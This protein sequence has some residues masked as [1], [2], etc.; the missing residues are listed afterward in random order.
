[1]SGATI[2]ETQT[3]TM[4]MPVKR[5]LRSLR[6]MLLGALLAAS[7]CLLSAGSALAAGTPQPA[8]SMHVS[9]FPTNFPPDIETEGVTGPAYLITATN[10]GASPTTGQFAVTDELP[11]GI[12]VSPL[13]EPTGIYYRNGEHGELACSTVGQTVTCKSFKVLV[14]NE[15]TEEEE[16]VFIPLNPGEVVKVSIFV[17]VGVSTPS[18]LTNTTSIEGGGATSVTKLTPTTISSSIADFGFS[19][20]PAGLEGTMIN[21]D[22]SVATQASS[23]PDEAELV[24][25]NFTRYARP[26]YFS[27][28]ATD[29]GLRDVYTNLP[30]GLVVNPNAVPKCKESQLETEQGCPIDTQV[31]TVSL[32]LSLVGDYTVTPVPLFNM[33]APGGV[34]ASFGFEIIDGIY[35]HIEGSVRTGGDYGLSAET[36]DILAKVVVGG[37]SANFWGDPTADSHNNV[38]GKCLRLFQFSHD[39]CPPTERLN[40]ALITMPSQCTGPI[41]TTMG[42]D[43]WNHPNVRVERTFESQDPNGNPVGVDGCNKVDFEPAIKSRPTTNVAD[44]PTGLDFNLHLTQNMEPQALSPAN[45]KD[46]RVT[47]PPGM[48]LNPSAADGLEGCTS[49]Q[50]DLNG[51]N[52]ANCPDTSKIGTLEVNTPLLEKPL[53]GSIYVAKPFDNP[54]DSLLAIYLAV[55]D[56]QTGVVVKLAGKAEP[57]PKT[58]QLTTTFSENPELPF[59]DFKLSFFKGT[60]AALK[61]A[62]FCGSSFQT[63]SR[64]TP[65]SSPEGAD[66]T[67]SD[68]FATTVAPVSGPCPTSEA[69]LP[70]KPTFTAGTVAP[71]AGAYSPFVLKLTRP[72][73]S[74][75]LTAIDATLPKGL[76]GKLAGIPYCSE[77]QIAAAKSREA[78]NQ[79]ALER[80]SPS[81]PLASEVGTVSVGA[82]AGISPIYVQGHAYLS[83]PY[84]GAPLSMTI[85]TP[86]VAGPFDLGSVVV[87]TALYVDSETAQIHAVSDPLPTIMD[88]IQLDVRSIAVALDRPSFTL[89]PTSCDPKTITGLASAALGPAAALSSPFQVG[90]CSALPFK[91]DLRLKLKGGTKRSDHPALTAVATAKPGEANIAS[92][93]AALPHS[94]F[95][96]Q[97]HI[98][99]ICT[100]VQF[101]AGA[102]PGEKCPAAS[103]YGRATATT[104]LLAEP[105]SGPVFLRSSSHPLPDLVAALHGQVDVVVAGRVDSVH[106]GIR[107]S[108]EAVPDAPVTKFTLEMQGGKKGLIVNS[109]DIC[110]TPQRAT[111]LMEAQ[112]GK[113]HDFKPVIKNS[114]KK[115]HKGHKKSS[116]S[117]R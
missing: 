97:A 45:L 93:S 113:T 39:V 74:Q 9:T 78:V 58:G 77:A 100:R 115:K 70:N 71:A 51:P 42:I 87:R 17:D 56:P 84:K 55:D 63:T 11:A 88:G 8:F 62:P 85:I 91:P 16:E 95:L 92:V 5:A 59:E 30:H 106:G 34:V 83:G 99:T 54:F 6:P 2:K 64:M 53:P 66:A 21:A 75:R 79:G 105:L 104:P 102:V 41:G 112:N 90:G 15:E 67:P 37:V 12:T 48:V 23:H 36:N 81:C 117:H 50:I 116:K 32:S 22:G 107:N 31:G 26:E 110:K 73:G 24:A 89:N 14:F 61:T 29:G 72:D 108:F 52:P 19:A 40:T 111:V 60:R 98:K 20:G 7:L 38:R 4:N 43:S 1:V 76:T 13:I 114:C 3:M 27:S 47:L 18:T 68:S 28:F 35:A 10:I 33:V 109:R 86:A 25:M 44:A 103:V 101:T 80:Q 96:D 94:E 82:G 49:A 65:W 69:A 57:D 46:A